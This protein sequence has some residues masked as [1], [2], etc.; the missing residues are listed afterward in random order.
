MNT[1]LS[2]KAMRESDAKTIAD[3]IPGREL[4]FRAGKAIFALVQWKPPVAVLCGSGN[5]GGDGYADFARVLFRV[6]DDLP[7]DS[8]YPGGGCGDSAVVSQW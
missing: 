3:G 6:N 2:V 7:G 4:M 5:N 8:Y 1:I